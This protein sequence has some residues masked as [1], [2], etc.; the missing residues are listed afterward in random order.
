MH[1]WKNAQFSSLI[2]DFFA[3]FF[4]QGKSAKTAATIHSYF[5]LSTKKEGI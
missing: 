4:R 5:S 2:P 1:I 3:C